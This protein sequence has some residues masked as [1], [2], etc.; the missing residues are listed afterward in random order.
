MTV[1]EFPK[2]QMA[3]YNSIKQNAEIIRTG[4]VLAIDPSSASKNSLPGFS[5]WGNSQLLLSGTV[6]VDHTKKVYLRLQELYHKI[7]ELLDCPPD[8]LIIESIH[9]NMAH[10]YLLWSV[11]VSIAAAGA[12]ICIEIPICVWQSVAKKEPNY[13]KTDSSD[14]EMMA[15]AAVILANKQETK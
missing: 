13:K 15:K 6:K 11:G 14:A 8:V 10:Q 1:I 12:P 2:G 4:V 7:Q 5:L 9:K 3:F